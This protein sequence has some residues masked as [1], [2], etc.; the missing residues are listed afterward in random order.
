[1]RIGRSSAADRLVAAPAAA[2][3]LGIAV[4]ALVLF[5]LLDLVRTMI[6]SATAGSWFDALDAEAIGNSLW[7]AAAAAILASAIGVGAAFATTC[8][9]GVRSGALRVVMLLPLL[10]PPFVSALAWT[11]AFGPGGLTDDLVGWTLPGLIGPAGIVLVLAVHA[12]PLVYL[13]AAAALTTRARPELEWAARISGAD[14]TAVFTRVTLPLLA[15]AVAGGALLAF[16]VSLNSFGIPAVLGVPAGFPTITTRI[17][18]DLARSAD[19]AAFQRV[20]MLSTLLMVVVVAAVVVAER[21]MRR[22]LGETRVAAGRESM[23]APGAGRRSGW[24]WGYLAVTTVIPLIA[25]GLTGLTRAAGLDP[26]PG[27]WTLGN[28]A[29]AWHGGTWGAVGRSLG[30]AA[31]AATLATTL[32]LVLSLVRRDRSD[33]IGLAAAAAFAVPGSALAVAVLIAYGPWLRDTMLIILIAYLAKFWALAHRAIAGSARIVDGDATRAARVSGASGP[34][35]LQ[36]VVLPMLRPALGAAWL[37]VFLFGLHEL[38]MSSLL[39]GPGTATLAVVTLEVQQLGD[40]TVTAAL[41]VLLT[42]PGIVA[43]VLVARRRVAS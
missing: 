40:V 42:V 41:A 43:A 11:R 6:E 39:Y 28:F 33:G 22:P 27:N 17:F 10:V 12:A 31:V 20:L 14:P 9:G 35:T 34:A 25:L 36:R 21:L 15:P 13:V 19:P 8:R 7:T 18:S 37:L 24:V 38:T 29:E 5:P 16:V 23:P 26:W 32:G 4:V 2:A 30:L 1:M 3:L